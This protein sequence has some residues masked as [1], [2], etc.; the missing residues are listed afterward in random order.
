MPLPLPPLPHSQGG[1]ASKNEGLLG[2][3]FLSQSL[4]G[5]CGT[6]LSGL[7]K[8]LVLEEPPLGGALEKVGNTPGLSSCCGALHGIGLQ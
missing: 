4:R 5:G 1:S 3:A 8:A 7:G 6:C 2:K